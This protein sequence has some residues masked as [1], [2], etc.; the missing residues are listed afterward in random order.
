MNLDTTNNNFKLAYDFVNQTNCSLYLTGK[1]G[2]GKT[3]FLKYV[4]SNSSKNLVIVAPTGVAAINAGG[5]TMHSFFQLPFGPYLPDMQTGFGMNEGVVDKNALFK[6]LKLNSTKRKLIEELQLLIID[7]VSML[8]SDTLDSIDTILK[9]FRK[10]R[11]PFGGVQILFIGDLYQLP[12]VVKDSEKALLDRHYNSP[13]FFD[14]NVLK[15]TPLVYIELKKI[16]RQNEQSFIDLLNKLRHNELEEEDFN[17]LNKRYDPGFAGKDKNYI[18]LTTHNHKA[19]VI[20]TE[21]LRKI[22]SKPQTFKGSIKGD[23]GDK[24]LPTD[25]QLQLKVGAQVMF[26]KNDSSPDKKY[27][28]GKIVV[29]SK[30]EEDEIY[31]RFPETNDEL[32]VSAETWENVNYALN[33]ETNHIDEKVIGEFCQVPL[34]LAWAI[35][36]HKSQG[37]TF[38][39]AIIDAGQ[40]FAPGQVYV[41]LSRCTSLEGVVLHSRI[42]EHALHTEDRIAVFASN[43]SNE[44]VLKQ[45]LQQEQFKYQSSRMISMFQWERI[46]DSLYELEEATLLSKQL[47]ESEKA[48]ELVRKLLEKAIEQ[49]NIADK[50]IAQLE[51]ILNDIAFTGNMTLLKE[52]VK[53]GI[54]YFV[55]SLYEEIDQPL[56]TYARSLAEKIKVKK[57]LQILIKTEGKCWQKITELQECIFEEEMLFDP[58]MK[59]SKDPLQIKASKVEKGA[60]SKESL[61][62]F[63]AGKTIEEIAKIRNMANSTVEKHLTDFIK[64]GELEVARF[65]GNEQLAKIKLAYLQSEDKSSTILKQILNDEF[66]YGEIRMALN[67]FYYKKEL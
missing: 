34:R 17:T 48:I 29:I 9:A 58:A 36:I 6:N 67:H 51:T 54:G 18:T 19:D 26:V 60:S 39:K 1:A 2:T 14:A 12:P 66:S 15:E 21:E 52:R 57:Y 64:T 32:K 44:K 55:K 47:P 37:L 38:E 23:F 35:T 4:K 3:T 62:Y 63:V 10:S 25:L 20:N 28:N 22:D 8:R 46:L 11:K 49:K 61:A 56:Q 65:L 16:Y 41:A 53:K 7:E 33:K 42:T 59:L 30:I 24:Q 43:E 45:Q 13:F 50:F 5:V 27:Y 31:V 40:S